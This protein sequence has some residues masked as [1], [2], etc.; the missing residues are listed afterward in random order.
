[1]MDSQF[2]DSLSDLSDSSI[3]DGTDIREFADDFD[4][5]NKFNGV[6]ISREIAEAVDFSNPNNFEVNKK[7]RISDDN[8]SDGG[9]ICYLTL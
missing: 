1:M 4:S 6:V 7:R 8:S 3:S 9:G 2:F 5:F